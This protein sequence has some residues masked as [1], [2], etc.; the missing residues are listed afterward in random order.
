MINDT[1][2]YTL[3]QQNSKNY[4]C[5]PTLT[6]RTVLTKI[7]SVRFFLMVDILRPII[8]EYSGSGMGNRYMKGSH[9]AIVKWEWI[10]SGFRV[11]GTEVY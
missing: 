6:K 10:Q 4:I 3:Q 11:T 1:I 7:L 2:H 8:N 5:P 9:F